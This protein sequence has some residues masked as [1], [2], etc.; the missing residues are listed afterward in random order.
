VALVR[1]THGAI[2]GRAIGSS[3]ADLGMIMILLMTMARPVKVAILDLLMA[4]PASSPHEP[5]SRLDG[6]GRPGWTRHHFEAIGQGFG[7]CGH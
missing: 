3:R 4:M 5:A 6:D 7:R 1:G 2:T